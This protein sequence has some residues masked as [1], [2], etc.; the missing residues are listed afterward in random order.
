M[1]S[2][3][4]LDWSDH[5]LWWPLR[6]RWLNRTRSTLDQYGVQADAKLEFTP[7]HKPLKIQLPSLKIIEL[8]VDFSCNVFGA[9]IQICKKCSKYAFPNYFIFFFLT[10]KIE[11]NFNFCFIYLK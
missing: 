6:N 3:I 11:N 2:D 1:L 9:V 5:A 7:M 8:M 4:A 10:S